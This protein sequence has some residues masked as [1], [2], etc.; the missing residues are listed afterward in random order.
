[1]SGLSALVCPFVARNLEVIERAMQDLY[2]I[3]LTFN[4]SLRRQ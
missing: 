1:M 2:R 3:N 4:A